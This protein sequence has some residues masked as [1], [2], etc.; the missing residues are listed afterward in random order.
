MKI[1]LRVFVDLEIEMH[2]RPKNA[3]IFI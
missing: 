3:F 2:F 1:D